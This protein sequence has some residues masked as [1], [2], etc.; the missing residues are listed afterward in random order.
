MD[1]LEKLSS[2]NIK[3]RVLPGKGDELRKKWEDSFV[4]HLSEEEKRKTHIWD[5]DGWGGY[6]WHVFSYKKREHLEKAEAEQAFNDL[7]KKVY[8]IFWEKSDDAILVED[9]NVLKFCDLEDEYDIY[10]VGRDF[11]W[12][13]VKTHEIVLCGPYFSEK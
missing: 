1:I 11:E 4:G 10:V 12:T 13:Y 6:L 9:G 3:F 2:R 8:Y 7:E 5:V